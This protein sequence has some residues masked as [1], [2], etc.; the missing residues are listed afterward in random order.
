M[1]YNSESCEHAV[2]PEDET[3]HLPFNNLPKLYTQWEKDV[4]TTLK[5]RQS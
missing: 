3:T 4:D 2:P 5:Q 1:E